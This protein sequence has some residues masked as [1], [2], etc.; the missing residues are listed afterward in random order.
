MASRWRRGQGG[1]CD[2]ASSRSGMTPSRV[3]RPFLEC[4][5]GGWASVGMHDVQVV[6]GFTN[7]PVGKLAPGYRIRWRADEL[8]DGV[9]VRRLARYPSHDRSIARRM[10]NYTSLAACALAWGTLALRGVDAMWVNGSP[11]TIGL[12]MWG[13]R[14]RLGIP[15]VLHVL[16][17]WPDTVLSSG[18]VGPRG[19]HAV[20][21]ALHAWRR[22]MYCC[23][24]RVAYL[25]LGVGPRLADRGV[26][27][28]KLA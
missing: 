25:S 27:A 15:V 19:Y 3:Q 12:P 20:E 21:T 9:R 18:V 10:L 4:S 23:S 16:D 1:A 28:A 22:R 24:D 13:V 26:P 6:T 8:R 17:L 11:I 14:Y 5:R 7:Y 2:S